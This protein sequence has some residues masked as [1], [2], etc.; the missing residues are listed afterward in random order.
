MLARERTLALSGGGE[1]RTPL[2]VPSISSAGFVRVPLG[3]GTSEPE[4]SFWLRVFHPFLQRALLISAYDVH[5]GNLPDGDELRHDFARS[6]YS[7][8]R[9][10]FLDSGLYESRSGPPP[11]NGPRLDWDRETYKRL[12]AELDPTSQTIIVNYDG[13]DDEGKAPFDCQIE[14]AQT[15]FAANEHFSSDLLIKP[16]RANTAL[17]VDKLTAHMKSLRG[18]DLIGVTEK[19]LGDSLLDKLRALAKLRT[20]LTEAKVTAPIHVFGSLDP[21]LAPL[22]FATGGEVFDGLTWLRYGYHWDSTIYRDQVPVLEDPQ[23]LSLSK[24]ERELAL[25]VNNLNAIGALNENMRQ[26]ANGGTWKL[27][28]DRV[29]GRLESAYRALTPSVGE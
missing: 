26:F 22:Y 12:V 10:L 25:L 18:F 8:D 16:D 20:R 15:F 5:H 23:N 7:G 21:V 6:I 19:E 11:R 4:S 2:L 14:T 3:D 28:G 17:D 1:L 24:Q 27:F 29:A 9:T 13:Y